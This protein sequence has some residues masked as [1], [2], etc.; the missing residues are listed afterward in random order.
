MKI[1]TLR[2]IKQMF[3]KIWVNVTRKGDSTQMNLKSRIIEIVVWLNL[4]KN[5]P[6][7]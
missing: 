7:G 1:K 4:A 5:N 2:I 3:L 6:V